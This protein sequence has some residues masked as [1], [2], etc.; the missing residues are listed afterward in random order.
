M[1]S[2]IKSIGYVLFYVMFQ[3]VTLSVMAGTMVSLGWSMNEVESFMNNNTM[4]LTI[5]TNVLTV[6]ILMAFYKVRK[7]KLWKEINMTPIS[8]QDCFLP[9]RV[10]FSYSFVFSLLTYNTSF[11]NQIQI[12]TC[13]EYYSD[14]VPYLGTIV[15][16]ITLLIIAPIAEEI[17]FRG[18]VLTTLQKKHSDFIAIALSGL[19]FGMIHIMAGGI[20]LAIGAAFMGILFGIVYVKTKSLTAAIITHAIANTSDFVIELLPNMSGI[21]QYSLMAVFAAIFGITLY[22]LIRKDI[23]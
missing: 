6:L 8:F 5:I 7:K 22:K 13:V 18:L 23:A 15:Q 3:V 12:K 16:I 1:K 14:L 11:E 19:F 10:A 4:G 2:I 17:I 9:C 21:M 20:L